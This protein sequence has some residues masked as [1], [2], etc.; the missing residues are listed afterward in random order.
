[1]STTRTADF[2]AMINEYLPNKL[3]Q[4]ELK[5][6]DFLF[7]QVEEDKNWKLVNYIVPF[8]SAV[9]SSV[10]FGSLTDLSDISK[11]KEVRGVISAHKEVWGTML[12]EIHFFQWEKE[13]YAVCHIPKHRYPVHLS[14]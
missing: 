9:A 5:K 13:R 2:A 12:F 14:Q 7:N 3:M 8:T 11:E 6:R 10:K 1:M 4:Q